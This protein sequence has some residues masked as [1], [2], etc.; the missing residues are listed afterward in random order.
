MSGV[1]IPGG[2]P[3]PPLSPAAARLE[4]IGLMLSLAGLVFLAAAAV[5]GAWLIGSDGR[6]YASDFVNLYAAGR[7]VL[8]GRAADAYDWA[9]H[10]QAEAAAVG[11]DF[12]GYYNWPYPPTFL[13]AVAPFALLPFVPA[14]FAWIAVTLPLYVVAIASI[15]G[16]RPGLALACAFPAVPWTISVGQNGFLTAALVGGTLAAWRRYPVLAGVL[17]GGLTYKPHFGLLFPVALIAA[18]RWRTIAAAAVTALLLAVAAGA[19]FGLESWAAFVRSVA[20]TGDLVFAE[21]RAGIAKQHS[22]LGLVRWLGGPLA[23]AWTLQGLLIA[24]AAVWIAR[25]W[26]GPACFEVKAAGLGAAVL[27]ATPYLYIYDFPVLAVPMAFLIRLGLADGFRRG[28]AAALTLA[29]VLVFLF[30]FVAVPTGLF[31]TLIVA[32]VAA[33]RAATPESADQPAGGH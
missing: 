25:L 32:L 31:A 12:G 30:P 9:A 2:V 33:R 26:R 4:A 17:L 5:Q 21:G 16:R 29:A 3:A 14:L 1:A 27:L 15:L 7:L 18:G 22:L 13:F 28:E 11:Y 10:G 24:A 20:T 8:E 23:L 6:P 19:A